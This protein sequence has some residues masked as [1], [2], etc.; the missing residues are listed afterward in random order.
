[1]TQPTYEELAAKYKEA[2]R[3]LDEALALTKS[4]YASLLEGQERERVMRDL[5]TEFL[6]GYEEMQKVLDST[7]D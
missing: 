2:Q 1:M 6:Q 5:I 4:L 7:R 3:L